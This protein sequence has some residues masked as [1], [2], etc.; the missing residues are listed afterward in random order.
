M[1]RF[2]TII[3]L[4]LLFVGTANAIELSAVQGTVY[5]KK[6]GTVNVEVDNAKLP[7]TLTGE[8]Y[9]TTSGNGKARLR[10]IDGTELSVAPNS[11]VRLGDLPQTSAGNVFTLLYGRVRTLVQKVPRKKP[12]RVQA[13]DVAM[14]VR[15]TE[16]FI[17]AAQNGS[18]KS[19]QVC[20][21]E[22]PVEVT[23]RTDSTVVN[24]TQG[25][26]VT[27]AGEISQ[28]RAMP[29][30]QRTWWRTQTLVDAS[31]S[32]ESF[33]ASLGQ[34]WRWDG[35]VAIDRLRAPELYDRGQRFV[36]GESV[37]GR[38][39]HWDGFDL[40]RDD[41]VLRASAE[42]AWIPTSNLLVH[43]KGIGA[44][45]SGKRNPENAGARLQEAFVAWQTRGGFSAHV[46]R[47]EWEF[48]DGFLIG[49]DPWRAVFRTFDGV[50]LSYRATNGILRVFSSTLED[51]TDLEFYDLQDWVHGFYFEGASTPFDLYF[52]QNARNGTRDFKTYTLGER[53]HAEQV[54]GGG[55]SAFVEQ[56]FSYQWKNERE[57]TNTA[58]QSRL[59]LGQKFSW[60]SFAHELKGVWLRTTGFE[61]LFQDTHRFW[62]L[63]DLFKNSPNQLQRYGGS[64]LSRVPVCGKPW[65]LQLDYSWFQEVRVNSEN[66]SLGREFDILT[67]VEVHP[68]VF[69][70]LGL[71]W[72]WAARG[73]EFRQ[74]MGSSGATQGFISAQVAL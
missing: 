38:A 69:L 7:Q 68:K 35:P 28:P 61:P 6:T 23:T 60:A 13:A 34:E 45:K 20:S 43:V 40:H 65:S 70:Q 48:G 25:V 54:T 31:D 29:N 71:S 74:I 22:G 12:W 66:V 32:M 67:G 47:Q 11:E 55:S 30:T 33:G 15:G 37:F 62:G 16:F 63:L 39:F 52:V 4:S 2:L 14:G 27:S 36:H 72:F 56:E 64:F 19:V 57:Q 49:K 59:E 42:A 3:I 24:S 41:T 1:N 26:W 46:G 9:L 50:H 58:Y 5:L 8:E 18:T 44:V 21:L 17:E 51:R 53:F 73:L 10:F